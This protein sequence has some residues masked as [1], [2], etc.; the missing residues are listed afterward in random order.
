MLCAPLHRYSS[1]QGRGFD[2]S[3]IHTGSSDEQRAPGARGWHIAARL[4]YSRYLGARLA[5]LGF[6][7]A[8]LRH[9]MLLTLKNSRSGLLPPSLL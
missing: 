4:R 8:F 2:I 6:K 5:M 3:L 1:Q 9:G 7:K